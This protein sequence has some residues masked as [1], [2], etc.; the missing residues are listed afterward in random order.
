M[1]VTKKEQIEENRAMAGSAGR[2]GGA[3]LH[4]TFDVSAQ[5]GLPKKP[6][7]MTELQSQVWDEMM[8]QLP[9]EA[10]RKIDAHMLYGL[11]A[12]VAKMRTLNGEFQH[13][14]DRDIRTSF[15]QTFDKLIKASGHFGLS[16]ADRKRIQ[17]AKPEEEEDQ[18]EEFM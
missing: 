18:L 6:A 15:L 13:S 7:S 4:G 10:L 14:D 16:P 5:D 9:L 1:R 8:E 2:S 12:L 11:T 3:R 17:I